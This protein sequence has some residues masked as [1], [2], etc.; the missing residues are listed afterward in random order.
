MI[1][2]NNIDV[3]RQSIT[4]ITQILSGKGI[5][6]TQTGSSAYVESVGGV[7][8]RINIPYI[9]DNAEDQ[10]IVAIN[11]FLDHEVAHVLFTN[12]EVSQPRAFKNETVFNI[13]NIIEDCRI[14]KQMR[15]KF[16][17]SSANLSGVG[18]FMIDKC[19]HPEFLNSMSSGDNREIEGNLFVPLFRAWSE[20]VVFIDY[21]RDKWEHVESLASKI[22]HLSKDIANVPSTEKSIELAHIIYDLIANKE[23]EKLKDKSEKGDKSE[24]EE[25]ES[26]E[27][28]KDKQGKSEERE[29]GDDSNS[30]VK[31]GEDDESDE[32]DNESENGDDESDEDDNE[33]DESE[34]GD[35]ESDEDDNES[36]EGDNESS[37]GD[38]E[39]SE[40]DNESSEGDNESDESENGDNKGDSDVGLSAQRETEEDSEEDGEDEE[41]NKDD[42]YIKSFDMSDAISQEMINS[43]DE[44]AYNIF[45]TDYDLVERFSVKGAY[46][47]DSH[48]SLQELES[49][50][51]RISGALQKTLERLI[52]VRSVSR[53]LPGKRSGK[54][55]PSALFKL[56]TGDNRVFKKKD[57]GIS[58]DV[59]ISL[60]VDCSGSMGNNFKIKLA[61][62][63]A[64]A[65]CD[66]LTKIN[67]TCEVI[68][69]TTYY[70]RV[71][72][73]ALAEERGRVRGLDLDSE[74]PTRYGRY[75]YSREEPLYMP[76]FKGFDEKFGIEQKLR[77]AAGMINQ[78]GY[79]RNN[80]DGECIRIAAKRLIS[81]TREKGKYM[82]VLSDGEP[83]AA[84]DYA[85]ICQDCVDA[86]L[87]IESKG[88]KVIGIG[89]LDN[90][91]ER[92]YKNNIVLDD[93]HNLP[94][95]IIDELKGILLA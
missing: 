9:P 31:F 74:N 3:V 70:D 11:G 67:V 30:N 69:F 36:S 76:I 33:S 39:S 72:I 27:G 18:Q 94:K 57:I 61:M 83:A 63:S 54:V 46:L 52:K 10:L 84:G 8:Q 81:L 58:N 5:K 50:T 68:G 25:S 19:I 28:E 53:N 71:A 29:E 80:V 82:I 62:E 79:M 56:K 1:K 47:D 65:I 35:N 37:E 6:V 20:Q 16:A 34:N 55:N 49:E 40:G 87:E 26:Q 88:I 2:N 59:A 77:M 17:G 45:S 64:F 12:F 41:K 66:V 13:Y 23:S 21:M 93:I 90:S 86:V 42:N 78:L 92:F 38:N 48:K 89:M 91:V 7:P 75:I 15:A 43:L 73:D 32:D 22:G 60:V 4:I 51:L 44:K 85:K 95:L 24:K 14:E